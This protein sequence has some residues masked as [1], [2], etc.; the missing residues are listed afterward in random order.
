MVWTDKFEYGGDADGEV[1]Y[2]F[3]MDGQCYE[4]SARR[5]ILAETRPV[6]SLILAEWDRSI[7]V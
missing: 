6:D 3:G 5:E 7:T 2:E 1:R 4:T